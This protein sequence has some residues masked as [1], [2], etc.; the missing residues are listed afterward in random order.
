MKK[1]LALLMALAMLLS[2]AACG[3]KPDKPEEKTTAAVSDEDAIYDAAEAYYDAIVSGNGEKIKKTMASVFE[4]LL[5]MENPF[6]GISD[7]EAAFFEQLYGIDITDPNAMYEVV[8]FTTLE[9]FGEVDSI[10]VDKVDFEKYSKKELQEKNQEFVDEGIDDYKV[11]DAAEGK[12]SITVVLEDGQEIVTSQKFIFVKEGDDWKVIPDDDG[13]EDEDIGY[14]ED[15]DFDDDIVVDPVDPEEAAINTAATA[16]YTAVVTANG[17]ALKNSMSDIFDQMLGAEDPLGGMTTEEISAFEELYNVSLSG[18]DA[19]YICF[20]LM[21]KEELGDP[22][23]I[24]VTAIDYEKFTEDDV[25]AF[26]NELVADGI[27]GLTITDYA[28][29]EVEIMLTFEDGTT[30]EDTH[31][32]SFIEENGAWKAFPDM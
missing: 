18:P 29:A 6:E 5:E 22:V 20:A 13:E 27:T 2:F 8:A 4:D 30:S 14:E 31:Y 17:A 28:E 19:F 7:E 3:D 25:A 15:I 24:R 32:V 1:L 12:A 9:E 23:N 26:N 11:N 21:T 10:A 16:Y